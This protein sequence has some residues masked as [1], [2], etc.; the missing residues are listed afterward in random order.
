MQSGMPNNAHIIE[1]SSVDKIPRDPLPMFHHIFKYVNGISIISIK[2]NANIS[3]QFS[4]QNTKYEK[5]LARGVIILDEIEKGIRIE[6]AY[7]TGGGC[8]TISP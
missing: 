5:H 4:H 8:K 1:L 3:K 7:E 6:A 2:P